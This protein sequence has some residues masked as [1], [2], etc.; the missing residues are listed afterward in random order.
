MFLR[1]TALLL[2]MLLLPQT[3]C[4]ELAFE[5][6][7]GHSNTKNSNV[8][9]TLLDYVPAKTAYE[10]I[11]GSSNIYG[12]RAIGWF[13][14]NSW[15]GVGADL[16]TFQANSETAKIRPLTVSTAVMFR[17]P[18]NKWKPY[19]ALG[20]T[21]STC[22]IDISRESNLGVEVSETTQSSYGW[23]FSTGIT[24]SVNSYFSLFAE[25]RYSH[26]NVAF[27][28]EKFY[29]SNTKIHSTLDSNH[30]LVGVSFT[31]AQ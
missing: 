3:L 12:M 20:L 28:D 6:Y 19:M 1:L 5:V 17:Y 23:D 15:V 30:Y 2:P 26:I 18:V 11:N 29:E 21:S 4:A 9:I 10:P 8:S 22:D 27:G 31:L 7:G 25:Y 14:H 24:W 16:Y 13:G